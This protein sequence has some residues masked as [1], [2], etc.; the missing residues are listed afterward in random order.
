MRSFPFD[1]QISEYDESGNPIYDRSYGSSELREKF[2]MLFGNGVMPTPANGMQVVSGTDM[3][4]IVKPGSGN[5]EGCLFV[6][7]TDRTLEVQAADQQDR[8]DR[9]VVRF[10]NNTAVRSTDLYVLKGTPAVSPMA[11]ELTRTDSYYELSLADLFIAKNTTSISQSRITDDRLNNQLCGYVVA[12][13][14]GIDTTTMFNQI[15]AAFDEFQEGFVADQNEWEET[16]EANFADW[17]S[18]LQVILDGDVAANLANQILVT[19][20]DIEAM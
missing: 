11:P 15:Q 7:D 10:N 19:E 2:K 20:A 17:F 13:P 1:S 14:G 4:V 3:T 16:Q 8:I 6:E 9:V 12:N 18:S 5:I